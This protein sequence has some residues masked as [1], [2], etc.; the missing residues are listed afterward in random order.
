[1]SKNIQLISQA[2]SVAEIADSSPKNIQKNI[3]ET[4]SFAINSFV[5]NKI[6]EQT[7]VLFNE[8]IQYLNCSGINVEVLIRYI[9]MISICMVVTNWIIAVKNYLICDT[10]YWM[11]NLPKAM[12]DMFRLCGGGGDSSSSS[13]SCSSSSSSKKTKSKSKS[14][15]STNYETKSETTTSCTY[16]KK[17]PIVW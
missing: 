6:S 5:Y 9:A 7:L 4:T 11:Y 2:P 17:K 15:P 8:F 14:T 10:Y 12:C 3:A 1:M 13:S 16:K